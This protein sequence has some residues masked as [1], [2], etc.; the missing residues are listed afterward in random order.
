MLLK[1]IDTLE[2]GL[3]VKDYTSNFSSLI[4]TLQILKE[5][6]QQSGK[7]QIIDIN[8]L[9]L[10]VHRNGIP[11]YSYKLSCNDFF[12]FFMEK[13]M[14][15]N[16]P[17]KVKFMS[18]YL[19]SYGYKQAIKNFI[20]WL[21]IFRITI[22]NTRISRLDIC[23]DTDECQF[24][25]ADTK[26]IV[27]RAKGKT[28][29]FADQSYTQGKLFSGF[30]VGRGNV[31]ARIYNKSLEINSSQKNWFQ[32][33]WYS[34]G[35]LNETVVWRVEFQVRRPV[36]KEMKINSFDDLD[37]KLDQL[38][39]YLTTKWLQIKQPSSNSVTRWRTK[40]K[41]LIIE[42][43]GIQHNPLPLIREKVKEG[44]L[45][46]LLDQ[47]AGLI[48]SIAAAGNYNNLNITLD[49]TRKWIEM[50]LVEK[51]KNF[52]AETIERRQK[53]LLNKNMR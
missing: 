41:W 53:F 46:R 29:Y 13:E 21:N 1:G 20:D 19:W 40:R 42:K 28:N 16:P 39:T 31:H 47:T 10:K 4:D 43:A 8:N 35:W 30:S 7:E 36:L 34:N 32:E 22:T 15:G 52:E 51:S 49:I 9:S 27:T 12:I 24:I 11:F 45:Q 17:I 44:N 50:K 25:E 18:S 2:F 37:K 33:I 6:N 5:S 38:W 26:G 3:D 48:I 14:K 23:V